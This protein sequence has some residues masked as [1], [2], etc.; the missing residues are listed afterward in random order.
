MEMDEGAPRTTEQMEESED[1][2]AVSTDRDQDDVLEASSDSADDSEELKIDNVEMFAPASAT[3][4]T[5]L[6]RSAAM[7]QIYPHDKRIRSAY[8]TEETRTHKLTK[9]KLEST[10]NKSLLRNPG[11][12]VSDF[13]ISNMNYAMKYSV[14]YVQS[15]AKEKRRQLEQNDSFFNLDSTFSSTTAPRIISPRLYRSISVDMLYDV[16]RE[17][18]RYRTILFLFFPNA[19]L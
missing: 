9:S 4:T 19:I 2:E 8:H 13:Y 6:Q 10:I 14:E 11:E 18:I 12:L 5:P 17:N 7:M 3:N 15:V 1:S 16:R